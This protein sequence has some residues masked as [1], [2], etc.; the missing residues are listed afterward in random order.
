[1]LLNAFALGMLVAV[2]VL[3]SLAWFTSKLSRILCLIFAA[4]VPPFIAIAAINAGSPAFGDVRLRLLAASFGRDAASPPAGL[5]GSAAGDDI[6][7]E[8]LPARLAEVRRDG[9]LV[10]YPA[11]LNDTAP[12]DRAY[13]AEASVVSIG[14]G[15]HESFLGAHP[16]GPAD[17]FCVESCEAPDAT[18]YRIDPGGTRLVVDGGDGPPLPEFRKRPPF[19]RA[20]NLL[21][22]AFAFF[23]PAQ[24][25]YPVR[26]YGRRWLRPVEPGPAVCASRFVCDRATT[27]PVRSFL[28]RA[29]GSRLAG[30]GQLFLA[31]LDPGA[32]I[33]TD[34]AAGRGRVSGALPP[35]VR[36]EADGDNHRITIWQVVYAD[37][38][39]DFNTAERPSYL[40]RRRAIDANVDDA[41]IRLG[42]AREPTVVISR[43]Q[44]DAAVAR[45]DGGGVETPV[46]VALAGTPGDP[47]L[48]PAG[49]V[50][51]LD[52]IGGVL[53]GAISPAGGNSASLVFPHTDRDTAHDALPTVSGGFN[54]VPL[55]PNGLAFS[56]GTR[57][58]RTIQLSVDR[59]TYPPN[60][61]PIVIFWAILFGL[62][63][64]MVWRDDATAIGIALALQLMLLMRI[65]VAVGS[66]ALDPQIDYHAG[67][68]NALI[69]YCLVPFLMAMLFPARRPAPSAYLPTGLM[70][71]A[72]AAFLA[73]HGAAATTL[74]GFTILVALVGCL[75]G[76]LRRRLARTTESGLIV[77][78]R[79]GLRRMRIGVRRLSRRLPWA[80]A[81]IRRWVALALLLFVARLALMLIFN[82]RER[83]WL[84]LSTIY[85]PLSLYVVAGLFLAI[86]RA[87]G[88]RQGA[89]LAWWSLAVIVLLFVIVPLMVSDIGYTFIYLPPVLIVGL[90]FVRKDWTP[91]GRLLAR[92]PATAVLLLI[93]GLVAIATLQAGQTASLASVNSESTPDRAA[94]LADLASVNADKSDDW[95]LSAVIHPE[96][97]NEAGTGAAEQIRRWRLLLGSFTYSTFGRGFPFQAEVSD[98]RQVQA[99]DNASAIHLIAPFGRLGAALFVL[100]LGLVATSRA[101]AAT[102]IG[103]RRIAGLLALAIIFAAAAYMI[104]ANLVLVPFTG[105]NVYFFAAHSKSDLIEGAVLVA[106][107]LWGLVS[108]APKVAP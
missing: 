85:L 68:D 105:R 60:L 35:R 63:Q 29:G 82:V 96:A 51:H 66:A 81:S 70:L 45:L 104:L 92:L 6:Y 43:D 7:I 95:R 73:W 83:L 36:L 16:I 79:R 23:R 57:D 47:A 46:A 86:R 49:N 31:L 84:A 38:D 2:I 71:I 10:A 20:G 40:I 61:I 90:G 1:M 75:L 12:R 42:F 91:S 55:R 103:V 102:R 72:L 33:E 52:A 8:G 54:A 44:I 3:L 100:A 11:R 15:S 50:V 93:A 69:A 9:L 4:A 19:S 87:P 77:K 25:V 107:A 18:W 22:D 99:S 30:G 13:W 74:A 78:V 34:G 27:R 64:A 59:F 62:L 32:V 17:R 48:E 89:R 106:M 101:G 97:L 39:I 14:E 56:A 24:A 108:H 76:G 94:L 58:S 5:G 37:A 88:P 65:F 53:A 41:R 21:A 98:L 80:P 67:L 26:D 28:F